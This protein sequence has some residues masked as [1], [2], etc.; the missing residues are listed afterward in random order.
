[1]ISKFQ[2]AAGVA[3]L[4]GPCVFAQAPPEPGAAKTFFYSTGAAG[5]GEHNFTYVASEMRI[6]GGVV[7]NAPYS[8][9]AITETTQKLADG[10]RISRKTTASL[11]RDSEGRTRREEAMGVPGAAAPAGEPPL[12]IFINDPVTETSFVLDTR[13]KI[14]RKMPNMKFP[15]IPVPPPPPA[16]GGASAS[17][18]VVVSDVMQHVAKLK[19]EGEMGVMIGPGVATAFS[20]KDAQKESLGTQMM[21][22]VQ[23]EGTRTTMTIP[24]GTI[25]NTS[26]FWSTIASMNAGP[27]CLTNASSAS[28]MSSFREIRRANPKPSA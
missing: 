12:S 15:S 27:G 23:A 19:A 26:A 1:M 28:L 14:A 8:A 9:Q 25:G 22:G 3:V 10:N 20:A 4:V 7:K 24:A 5:G 11:Y 2:L 17:G 18:G 21:E 6:E 16:E 13:N